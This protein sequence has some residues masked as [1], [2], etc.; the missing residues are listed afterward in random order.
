MRSDIQQGPVLEAPRGRERAPRQEG[1][2]HEGCP[3]T[4]DRHRVRLLE[5]GADPLRVAPRQHQLCGHSRRIDGRHQLLG[6]R[7]V[8]CDGLLEQQRFPGGGGQGCQSGLDVGRQRER[9]GVTVVEELGEV[10]GAET[11]VLPCKCLRGLPAP[12]VHRTHGG[13][14]PGGQHR[15]MEHT[16]PGPSS[17][18]PYPHCIHDGDSAADRRAPARRQPSD[19]QCRLLDVRCRH[20]GPAL[21]RLALLT[22]DTGSRTDVGRTGRNRAAAEVEWGHDQST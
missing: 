19:V 15:R 8:E 9:D 7:Q 14:W 21:G 20:T 10:V 16:C 6:R 11:S 18:D 4:R 1:P 2:G 3:K 12:A 13:V 5:E 22:Q 17:G